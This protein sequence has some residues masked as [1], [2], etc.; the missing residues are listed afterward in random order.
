MFVA[1]NHMLSGPM[2]VWTTRV[3]FDCSQLSIEKTHA[4]ALRKL[5]VSDRHNIGD[6]LR[7]PGLTYSAFPSNRAVAMIRATG[8]VY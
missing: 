4:S 5:S 7:G 2:P 6:P 1:V 8:M 3:L